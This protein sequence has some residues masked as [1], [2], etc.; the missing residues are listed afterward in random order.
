MKK[1]ILA[2]LFLASALSV[3]SAYA[4]CQSEPCKTETPVPATVAEC[5]TEACY[6]TQPV[7]P[8]EMKNLVACDSAG[9][10]LHEESPVLPS[11]KDA[12][13]VACDNSACE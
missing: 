10:E 3:G 8:A 6:K 5:G 11:L 12:K 13:L 7:V 9:C 4:E 1:T 2:S